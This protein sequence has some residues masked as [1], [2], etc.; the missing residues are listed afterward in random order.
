M[1]LKAISTHGIFGVFRDL[2]DGG[3]FH[4]VVPLTVA[5]DYDEEF[6]TPVYTGNHIP[7]IDVTCAVCLFLS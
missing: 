5:Y 4:P 3:Y 1:S 2:F 6:I 7:P